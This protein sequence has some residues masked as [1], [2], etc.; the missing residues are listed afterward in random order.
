MFAKLLDKPKEYVIL[1]IILTKDVWRK[2]MQQFVIVTDSSCD[3]SAQ[4]ALDLQLEVLPLSVT[5]EEN[6]YKNYLDGREISAKDFYGRI[7]EGKR[8]VTSAV[9]TNAFVEVMEPLLMQGTDILY[10]GFSSGLSGTYNAGATAVREL[11]EKYPQRKIYAVDTLCASMGEGLLIYLAVQQKNTGKTIEEVRDYAE[12]TKWKICHWFTVENLMQLKKGGRIS[13]TTAIVGTML[14]IKPVMHMDMLGKL[15]AVS[16]VRGRKASIRAL[17]NRMAEHVVN[18]EGQ[19][20]FISHGDCEEEARVLA[21]MIREQW[22][23]KDVVLNHVGPV[24]GAHTG[25][26]VIALFFLGDNR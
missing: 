10:L 14:N 25:P 15:A 18:P 20:I 2:N 22:P 9:N 8:V 4:M 12:E 6:T 7:R 26:G 21:E 23:V 17:F 3:L 13:A 11:A 24:I 1:K 5:I 19:M 16:K